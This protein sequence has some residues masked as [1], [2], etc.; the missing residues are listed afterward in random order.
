MLHDFWATRVFPFPKKPTSQGL[1]VFSE[2]NK[3]FHLGFEN[4][5]SVMW[6]CKSK[7]IISEFQVVFQKVRKD[8]SVF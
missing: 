2:L 6:D 1:T 5:F 3:A 7:N 4:N 8:N